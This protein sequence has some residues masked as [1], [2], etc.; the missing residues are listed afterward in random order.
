MA[1]IVNEGPENKWRFAASSEEVLPFWKGKE[2]MNKFRSM[3]P[4]T[5]REE[6]VCTM[7]LSLAVT[8]FLS[9]MS[10]TGK[11]G[12]TGDRLVHVYLVHYIA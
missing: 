9:Y 8:P 4:D 11:T 3:R 6:G 10:C 1:L 7:H 2:G 12:Y 5:M